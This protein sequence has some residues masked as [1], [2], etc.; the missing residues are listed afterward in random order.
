MNKELYSDY[1][2]FAWVYN[3]HWGSYSKS[4]VPVLE[5]LIFPYIPQNGKI[6]DLCCGTGQL[7]NSLTEKGYDVTGI[8]GSEE[9]IKFAR[10]NAPKA[11]F[12]IEDARSFDFSTCF[13]ATLSVFDSLNHLM[14]L[15]E[16]EAVFK[17]V[18]SVLNPGGLFLFDLNMEEG[19]EKQW[20]KSSF[21]MVEDDH[22]CAVRSCYDRD[23]KI[24]KFE[25]TIFRQLKVWER[26]DVTLCQRCYSE[27]EVVS[28][29]EKTG[30][31]EIEVLDAITDLGLKD[32]GRTYFLGKRK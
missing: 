20:D 25:I 24:G 32:V 27:V 17:N 22:V 3:R 2:N 19:F 29:L 5:K 21:N 26:T 1:N 30:F 15:K 8:D 18:Y 31:K 14:E 9:M 16:L 23:N 10:E 28:V 12:L 6:L 13:N 11:N 4:I 7:A